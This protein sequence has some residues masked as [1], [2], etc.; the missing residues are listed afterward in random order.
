MKLNSGHVEQAIRKHINPFQQTLI[1][2]CS[3]RCDMG[4]KLSKNGKRRYSVAHDY[5]ADFITMS[6]AGYATEIEVKTSRAD[7]R[8]DLEK[9]KWSAMPDYISRFIYVVP[10]ALGLPDFVPEFAGV[11]HIVQHGKALKVVLIRAPKRIGKEKVPEKVKTKWM[12][13]FYHRYWNQRIKASTLLPKLKALKK[14]K[15][16]IK[17]SLDG[18]LQDSLATLA[19]ANAKATHR[20]VASGA[21]TIQ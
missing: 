10:E 4:D 8:A 3:V 6:V 7:W 16:E 11:W 19:M 9:A 20:M 1:P 13:V 14:V 5:K 18:V 2:E 12:S 17:D 21:G 15:V